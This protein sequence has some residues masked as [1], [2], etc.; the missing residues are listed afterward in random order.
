LEFSSASLQALHLGFQAATILF[1]IV[2][3][4]TRHKSGDFNGLLSTKKPMF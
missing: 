4:V 1:S 2:D 3:E